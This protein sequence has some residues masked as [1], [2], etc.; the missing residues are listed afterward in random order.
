[1]AVEA[2]IM[3]YDMFCED[4][5]FYGGDGLVSKGVEQTIKNISALGNEG[6]KQTDLKI[7]EI[8]TAMGC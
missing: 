8:M 4:C 2:G 6:M 7:I 1:M 3:G 5:Q